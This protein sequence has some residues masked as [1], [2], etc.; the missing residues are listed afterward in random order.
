[1]NSGIIVSLVKKPDGTFDREEAI[2]ALDAELSRIEAIRGEVKAC[3]ERELKVSE[4]PIHWVT[5]SH[6]VLAKLDVTPNNYHLVE[7]VVRDTIKDL[8]YMVVTKKPGIIH[9]KTD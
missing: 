8:G 7:G 3:V 1:M 5:F 4:D 2:G 9:S 6:R